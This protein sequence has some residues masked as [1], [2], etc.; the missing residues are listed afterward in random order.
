[1]GNG[2]EH[3]NYRKMKVYLGLCWGP[4]IYANH[5]FRHKGFWTRM[6]VGFLGFEKFRV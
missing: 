1:M 3:G 2:E 4:P 6:S 5:N